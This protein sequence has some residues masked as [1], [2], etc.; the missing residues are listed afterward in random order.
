VVFIFTWVHLGEFGK[1][2]SGKKLFKNV[3]GIED[4]GKSHINT[5]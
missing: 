3:Y 1:N 4:I 2:R 5:L